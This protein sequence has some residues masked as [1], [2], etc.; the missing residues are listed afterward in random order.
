MIF[1]PPRDGDLPRD[2]DCPRDPLIGMMTNDHSR[3]R[4]HPWGCLEDF[5]E[6]HLPT[7]GDHPND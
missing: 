2:G 3:D 7:D 6:G 1:Y 5:G 4:G